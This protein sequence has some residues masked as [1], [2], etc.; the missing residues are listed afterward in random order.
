M[1][2]ETLKILDD[3][4]KAIK[5]GEDSYAVVIEKTEDTK[6]KKLL[7]K[8]SKNYEKFLKHINKEYK[9]LDKTPADTKMMQKVM[10][11]TGIKMN[12]LKDSSASHISEML[13][14]GAIMGYIECHKLLNSNL[15]ISEDL[16]NEI[17]KFSALQLD[18]I[19]ELTPYLK[20]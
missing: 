11:W 14:Q 20:K 3:F 19:K 7:E 8:Q 12:M 17:T 15:D 9:K 1:D 18:V 2:K 16:K 10:G 6:F 5:M 13:I 4:N